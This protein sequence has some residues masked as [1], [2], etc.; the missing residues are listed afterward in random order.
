MGSGGAVAGRDSSRHRRIGYP[1]GGERP[2]RGGVRGLL[3]L[4]QALG[5]KARLAI[6]DC[7]RGWHPASL[8]GTVL[9]VQQPG[10][11]VMWGAQPWQ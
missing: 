3:S 2:V 10:P 5:P 11:T 1:D 9:A 7:P 8:A 6:P 4:R